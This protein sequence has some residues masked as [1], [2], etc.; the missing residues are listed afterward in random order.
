M[1]ISPAELARAI[2]DG[3]DGRLVKAE[4]LGHAKIDDVTLEFYRTEPSLGIK[5][6]LLHCTDDEVAVFTMRIKE[7]D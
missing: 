4:G 3:I 6:T 1:K 7:E 2:A 5:L